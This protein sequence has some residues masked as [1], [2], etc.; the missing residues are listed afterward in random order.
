MKNFQTSLLF[1]EN[2]VLNIKDLSRDPIRFVRQFKN[3]KDQEL[4]G[5]IAAH[6]SYGRVE[7]IQKAIEKATKPLGDRPSDKALGVSHD[8]WTREYQSAIHDWKWRFHKPSD[9]AHW[10]RG[11]VEIQQS[12]GLEQRLVPT[13]KSNADNQLGLLIENLK[14]DLPMSYGLR[15]NLPNPNEGSTAKRWRMMIRWFVRSGWPD[16]GIWSRYPPSDLIIPVDVHIGRITRYLG[17]HNQKGVNNKLAIR[18]TEALRTVDPMDPLRFDYPLAHL[19]IDGNC[20]T[21]LNLTICALCPLY[22][23]CDRPK[24]YPYKNLK[25]TKVTI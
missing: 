21:K 16:L 20:P 9:I 1:L 13:K 4:I 10:I 15:F 11:W 12:G 23:V 22:E 7:G 8:Y 17:I 14:K 19:G 24:G 6:L 3:P 2:K 25:D 18:I 5:W